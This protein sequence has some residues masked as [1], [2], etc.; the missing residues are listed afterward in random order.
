MIETSAL[1]IGEAGVL[2]VFL[3]P[4]EVDFLV[5]DVEIAA[6]D[7]GLGL[8]LAGDVLAE[9]GVPCEAVGQ[10]AEAVLCVGRVNVDEGEVGIFERENA[11][12]F[13]V[14]LDAEAFFDVE[15]LLSG[16]NGDAGVAG[17]F[18]GAPVVLVAAELEREFDLL[19]AGFG[20]LEAEDVGVLG[21]DEVGEAFFDGGADA[22]DVPGNEFHG[23]EDS[24]DGAGWQ[25]L[26]WLEWGDLPR[27]RGGL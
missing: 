11:A 14:F 12:F 2:A 26:L 3:G 20:F 24:G 1:G 19:G 21:G 18:G 25:G 15:R 17:F 9:G 5:G 13:V 16:E 23:K 10:A 27:R 6:E 22:V 8:G 7:D 4:R